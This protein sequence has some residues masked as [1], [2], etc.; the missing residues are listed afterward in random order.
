MRKIIVGTLTSSVDLAAALSEAAA[1][2]YLGATPDLCRQMRTTLAR[3]NVKSSVTF[4]TFPELARRFNST[5]RQLS[6]L[7]QELL[8]QKLAQKGNWPQIKAMAKFPGFWREVVRVVTELAHGGAR[9]ERLG[10]ADRWPGLPQEVCELYSAYWQY[11]QKQQLSDE[12]LS[13]SLAK[14][15]LAAHS[16]THLV[17]DGFADFTALQ[18]E[19]LRLLCQRTEHVLVN[20]AGASPQEAETLALQL[21]GG[22]EIEQKQQTEYFQAGNVQVHAASSLKQE[23]E[24]ACRWLKQQIKAGIPP[25]QLVIIARQPEKYR[26]QVAETLA[27]MGIPSEVSVRVDNSQLPPVLACKTALELLQNNWRRTEVLSLVRLLLGTEIGAVLDL[28]SR[29]ANLFWG[30]D[31]WQEIVEKQFQEEEPAA[32]F[33]EL[34]ELDGSQTIAERC[35]K[36]WQLVKSRTK[37]S[38]PGAA[39]LSQVLALSK[40]KS[41]LDELSELASYLPQELELAE[42]Q[43][44]FLRAI[45]GSSRQ[46]ALRTPQRGTGVRLVNPAEA[47]GLFWQG[48]AVLGLEEGEYPTPW[49]EDWFFSE[50]M[51]QSFSA[52]G[53]KLRTRSEMAGRERDLFELAV[54]RA[55][56]VLLLSYK[57]QD[58]DGQQILPSPYLIE[59]L[60]G[61]DFPQH[62]FPIAQQFPTTNLQIASEQ[63]LAFYA[64][65]TKNIALWEEF[66]S[67]QP[68]LAR[69]ILRARSLLEKRNS[70]EW[71]AFDGYLDRPEVA[72]R[73]PF[74]K[75]HHYSTG[76]LET[77]AKC[78]F[79]F[80]CLEIL[81]LKP[82]PELDDQL[83]PKD[84]GTVLH[85]VLSQ[86]LEKHKGE[87]LFVE[88]RTAY[89]AELEELL[90][91]NWPDDR[92][93]F[94]ERIQ[95]EKAMELLVNFLD[96]ELKRQ[97]TAG[98]SMSPRSLEASF[99]MRQSPMAEPLELE[100]PWGKI[101]IRGRIDRLDTSPTGDFLV[102]DYKLGKLPSNE[103]L[104]AGVSLQL[105][106]Y[107][108]AAEKILGP[109]SRPIGALFYSLK[110]ARFRGF[111]REEEKIKTGMSSRAKSCF[112]GEWDEIME[113]F[114][115][116]LSTYLERINS[117]D[118]R[119]WPVGECPP[120]CEYKTVCRKNKWRLARKEDASLGEK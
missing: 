10:S 110:N 8:L 109:H 113:W 61:K 72:A 63:E 83:S 69:N 54:S 24:E 77:Y 81:T 16:W 119:V 33:Q 90:E 64:Q 89:L 100:L 51:R 99:G 43:Q 45:E 79:R 74:L 22:F 11:L 39:G 23:V 37:I 14:E 5:R 104:A 20:L 101:C 48:A 47:R 115:G 50:K 98:Y 59:L 102:I 18:E 49:P 91:V 118:F 103:E 41:I 42:F 15:Q 44:L 71:T 3:R 36:L 52:A 76:Q 60:E 114:R 86:F 78:P 92:V 27:A 88:K 26:N 17:V 12:A 1:A 106:V 108:W 94:F 34:V 75:N 73:L 25:S 96:Q 40:L 97:Q 112:R 38:E 32:L 95:Q 116:Q 85:E 80:Y 70:T 30:R 105:P 82:L 87:F 66:Q 9:P 55:R 31:R 67:R 6:P 13:L 111:W 2:L 28:L 68:Q 4:A 84:L 62:T 56:Q 21:G 57:I 7:E 53:I 46:L 65:D 93:D 120:F 58:E 19:C 107:L 117:G 35:G 29:E